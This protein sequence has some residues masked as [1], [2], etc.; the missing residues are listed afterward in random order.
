[1]IRLLLSLLLCYSLSAEGQQNNQ[2]IFRHI[3]Q[4]DGLL[5]NSVFAITQD[6]QGFMWIGTPNGLQ[7]YDGLRFKN[8]EKELMPLSYSTPIKN[9]YADNANNI[10]ITTTQ[11]ARINTIK[12]SATVYDEKNLLKKPGEKFVAYH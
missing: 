12:N 8:Y 4:G 3:D 11:L 2:Y 1:M 5:H 9:I 7:R 10:W 6:Q